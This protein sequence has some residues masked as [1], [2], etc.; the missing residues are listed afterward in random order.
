MGTT[1][2]CRAEKMAFSFNWKE[3][4]LL[5]ILDLPDTES[6][7]KTHRRFKHSMLKKYSGYSGLGKIM[8]F[9]LV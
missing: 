1:V 8:D 6:R 2:L 4:S 9:V 5:K 3:G 7:Q